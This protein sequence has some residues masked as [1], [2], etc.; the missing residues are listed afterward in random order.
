[1]LIDFGFCILTCSLTSTYLQGLLAFVVA[2]PAFKN[3]QNFLSGMA[4]F[5]IVWVLVLQFVIPWV[6]WMK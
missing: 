2:I 3:N 6:E 4:T 1:M 5:F